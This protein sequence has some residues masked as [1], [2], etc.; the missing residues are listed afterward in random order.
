MVIEEGRYELLEHIGGGEQA[1]IWRIRSLGFPEQRLAAKLWHARWEERGERDFVERSHRLDQEAKLLGA[2]INTFTVEPHFRIST[3]EVVDGVTYIVLG[4]AMDLA[5]EGSLSDYLARSNPSIQ[6]KI[7]L[8]EQL[9]TGL[10]DLQQAEI[11]HNDIKPANILVYRSGRD[12]VAKYTDFGLAFKQG[13]TPVGGGTVLYMAPELINDFGRPSF[14][15]TPSAKTDVYSLGIVF[16]EIL[17]GSHPFADLL[18]TGD[19]GKGLAGYFR[20]KDT[21]DFRGA[22]EPLDAGI[23]DLVQRMCSRDPEN[24]PSMFEVCEDLSEARARVRSHDSQQFRT[25]FPD[26]VDTFRWTDDVHRAFKESEVLAFLRGPNLEQDPEY[27]A[28]ALEGRRLHGFSIFRL[29]G[30]HDFLLRVW[31]RDSDKKALADV[32]LAYETERSGLLDI[33]E[34]MLRWPGPRAKPKLPLT[35]PSELLDLINA[36]ASNP[37]EKAAKEA[38]RQGLIL[39]KTRN[40]REGGRAHARPIRAICRASYGKTISHDLAVVLGDQLHLKIPKIAGLREVE[41]LANPGEKGTQAV[42]VV[43]AELDSFHRYRDLLL[44]LERT[45]S[46]HLSQE[47]GQNYLRYRSHFE[48]DERSQY[49]SYDGRIFYELERRRLGRSVGT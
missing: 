25:Q 5:E 35:K 49:E 30:A 31:R 44:C 7:R 33:F 45:L 2:I 4:V 14:N 23:V 38:K 26:A 43:I 13:T 11:V 9:A 15:K 8:M 39:G 17:Q 22:R 29:L 16:H 21:I 19:I 18:P 32:L 24:R 41:V 1:E 48:M 36:L 34:P 42:F 46:V 10:A 47:R 40:A 20:T 27:L 28:R 3:S 12:A 37:S 6:Q